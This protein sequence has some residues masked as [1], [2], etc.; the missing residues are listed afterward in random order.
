MIAMGVDF[1]C[2]HCSDS[3]P[4]FIRCIKNKSEIIICN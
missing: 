3:L 4:D 1:Y 2:P